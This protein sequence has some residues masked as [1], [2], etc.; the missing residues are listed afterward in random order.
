MRA[1]WTQRRAWTVLMLASLLA[2]VAIGGL[3]TAILS[4]DMA[5]TA[6]DADNFN[7][8]DIVPAAGPSAKPAK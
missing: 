4:E 6:V 5:Q 8:A 2:W 1:R 7:P 3:F